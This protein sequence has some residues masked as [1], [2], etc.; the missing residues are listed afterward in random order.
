M[1]IGDG[2]GEAERDVERDVRGGALDIVADD[3]VV[4][5]DADMDIL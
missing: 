5:A 2:R 3:D 4:V 1:R